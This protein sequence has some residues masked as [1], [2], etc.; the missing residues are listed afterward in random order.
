MSARLDFHM[1]VPTDRLLVFVQDLAA[2]GVR[3]EV[4]MTLAESRPD[5][6]RDEG[7]KRNH[8]SVLAGNAAADEADEETKHRWPK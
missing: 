8:D 7:P 6:D 5:S 1:V 2:G 3:V 4:S